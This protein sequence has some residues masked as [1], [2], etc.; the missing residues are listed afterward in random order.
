MENEIRHNETARRFEAGVEPDLAKLNY[1]V[2]GAVVDLLHV[3]VPDRLQGQGLA[4]K[5]AA[6]ALNWARTKAFKV[7][8][9][10]PYVKG[11]LG[12]HPEYSDLL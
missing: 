7:I 12:K 2:T 4:G 1:R 3:E 9:T 10:C 11:Y 8:P 5:L 6:A